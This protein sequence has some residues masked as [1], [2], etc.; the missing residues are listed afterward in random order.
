MPVG[1]KSGY[2]SPK[3]NDDDLDDARPGEQDPSQLHR[4]TQIQSY[5]RK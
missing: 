5:R 3:V 4:S 1:A 2:A